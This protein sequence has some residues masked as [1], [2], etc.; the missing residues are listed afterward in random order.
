MLSLLLSF[1]VGML[2]GGVLAAYLVTGGFRL[3]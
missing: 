1:G 2:V 3:Y